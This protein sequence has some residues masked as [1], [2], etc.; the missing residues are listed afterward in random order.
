MQALLRP[1][2]PE[3]GPALREIERRAGERFRS[4]GR[5]EIAD[6]EPLP[7]DVLAAYARAGRSW[8]AVGEDDAPA[9]YVLVDLVDG[10]AHIEQVTVD[11]GR[12]GTGLGRALVDRS[13]SWAAESG[14]AGVTL[15]TF[16]DVPWNA[17]LYR[18][19][20]FRVLAG[21][22]LGPGLRAV[23]EAEAAHGLDPTERVVMYLGLEP[24]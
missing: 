1:A 13:R 8:V 23:L 20:G 22:E 12:Q 7:L 4:V 10:C 9:G 24:A 18:H 19:L 5:P 15:T 3:D 17:P 2:R 14:L 6:D 16:A 11:P 21:D